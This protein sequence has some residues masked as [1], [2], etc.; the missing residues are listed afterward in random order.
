MIYYLEQGTV[1]KLPDGRIGTAVYNG[2]DGYGIAW[3]VHAK[4][5]PE[6][7]AMLRDPYPSAI[8]D[9]MECVGEVFER[10]KCNCDLDNWE[11]EAGTG[12]SWVCRIHKAALAAAQKA[13]ADEQT[14]KTVID[15]RIF[16][17]R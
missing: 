15:R 7:E 6:A 13:R 9:G 12:H 5:Y 1:V 4:P 14:R 16:G 8:A 10:I 3:G 2:L 11:P 17:C